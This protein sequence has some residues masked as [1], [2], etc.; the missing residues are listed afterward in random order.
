MHSLD[1][2]GAGK[3]QVYRKTYYFGCMKYDGK[4]VCLKSGFHCGTVS[5]SVDMHNDS[6][7]E[8]IMDDGVESLGNLC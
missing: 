7:F 4:H 6:Y 1:A 5:C 8:L 3:C 2:C